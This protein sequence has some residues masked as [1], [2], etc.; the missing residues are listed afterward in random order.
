M[1]TGSNAAE[2]M[3]RTTEKTTRTRQFVS[4]RLPASWPVHHLA[5]RGM[6]VPKLESEMADDIVN[7]IIGQTLGLC[8]SSIALTL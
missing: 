8:V 7:D 1:P 6:A 4:L 5:Q 3:Q 2:S